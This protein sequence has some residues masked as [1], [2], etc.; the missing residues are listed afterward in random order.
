MGLGG[1]PGVDSQGSA[2]LSLQPL[3]GILMGAFGLL[4]GVWLSIIVF[5]LAV[6]FAIWLVH[7]FVH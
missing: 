6:I 1:Y 7:R 4:Q 3:V 2:G 5:V